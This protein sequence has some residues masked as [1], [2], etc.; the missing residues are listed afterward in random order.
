MPSEI[1]HNYKKHRVGT[2]IHNQKKNINSQTIDTPTYRLLPLTPK[3]CPQKTCTDC[4]HNQNPNPTLQTYKI[5]NSHKIPSTQTPQTQT[6]P[7]SYM[8]TRSHI[9]KNLPSYKRTQIQTK[10]TTPNKFPYASPSIIPSTITALTHHKNTRN[11]THISMKTRT[12]FPTTQTVNT[13]TNNFPHEN[14][15]TSP[16]NPYNIC[17]LK[18][19]YDCTP[20][21]LPIPDP[22]THTLKCSLKRNPTLHKENHHLL[23]KPLSSHGARRLQTT[24]SISRRHLRKPHYPAHT[25][26]PNTHVQATR[27]PKIVIPPVT[28]HIYSTPQSLH[29]THIQSPPTSHHRTHTQLTTNVTYSQ[30]CPLHNSHYLTPKT[31]TYLPSILPFL[32]HNNQ[33]NPSQPHLN[34]HLTT[35]SAKTYP[36]QTPTYPIR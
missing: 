17:P 22:C 13:V 14:R 16:Q 2:S 15:Q 6:S 5:H 35:N 33:K 28:D 19:N 36:V 20:Q 24:Q 29:P 21:P 10:L 25:P 31:Y 32:K 27:Q 11:Q 1:T 12:N 34:K 7:Y 30:S 9:H 4:H 18:T 8:Q 3:P 26:I 23:Y